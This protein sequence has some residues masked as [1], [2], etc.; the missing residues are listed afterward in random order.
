M[1]T[2]YSYIGICVKACLNFFL[3]VILSPRRRRRTPNAPDSANLST[4][5]PRQSPRRDPARHGWRLRIGNHVY[6]SHR[7]P[8][9]PALAGD[10]GSVTLPQQLACRNAHTHRHSARRHTIPASAA[11]TRNQNSHGLQACK[12][13]K[14][15]H[16][17]REGLR[18]LPED[19][20]S[21]GPPS[22]LSLM[23]S[24]RML[25]QL[26]QPPRHQTFSRHK[27]PH[28]QIVRAGRGLAL[29]LC[30]S[31]RSLRVFQSE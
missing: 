21:V 26:A 29:V 27:A 28:R 10:E 1:S 5:S 9:E 30:G 8:E 24:R 22:A 19:R 23:R 12:R 6:A 11:A 31:D 14:E 2:I 25:R 7:H 17:I 15:R 20:R 4:P 13:N 18:G 16:P 3:G